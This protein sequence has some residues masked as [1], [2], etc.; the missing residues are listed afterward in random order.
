[1]LRSDFLD[2]SRVLGVVDV[3]AEGDLLDCQSSGDGTAPKR[4]D[5]VWFSQQCL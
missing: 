1:M 4:L 5:V 2:E 3:R